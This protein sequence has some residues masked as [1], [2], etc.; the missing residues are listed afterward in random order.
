[1]K[2]NFKL[3]FSIFVAII[4]SISFIACGGSDD[5]DDQSFNSAACTELGIPKNNKIINGVECSQKNSSIVLLKL[6][7]PSKIS[8]CTGT[9]I[10]SNVVL[11]A[12][13]CLTIG[14]QA[15]TV[16]VGNN[17]YQAV[18][19]AY[20]PKYNLN[21]SPISEYNYDRNDIGLILIN[22]TFA[23][24]PMPII[25][26][27]VARK[28][29]TLIVAG[30]GQDENGGY[31]S[32]LKAAYMKVKNSVSSGFVMAYDDTHTNVCFGDSGGPAFGYVNGVLG[33]YGVT[34]AGTKKDCLKGDETFFPNFNYRENLNFILDYV[35]PRQL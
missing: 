22:G 14:I 10:S 13:H 35:N 2:K 15:I 11:T 5:D 18:K 9:I 32:T 16:Q 20:H 31:A 6:K 25:T 4:F 17:S 21:P 7:T 12:A 30:Y 26:S 34:S 1:M 27:Q 28:G 3:F 23:E 29:E 24:K 33:V 8:Y 19:Y